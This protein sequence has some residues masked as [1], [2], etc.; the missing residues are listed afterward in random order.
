MEYSMPHGSEPDQKVI[1]D[2]LSRQ[3][4]AEKT[5]SDKISDN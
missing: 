3:P 4:M 1:L 5:D 2:G